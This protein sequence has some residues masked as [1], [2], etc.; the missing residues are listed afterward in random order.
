[1]VRARSFA[2]SI[3]RLRRLFEQTEVFYYRKWSLPFGAEVVG[4]EE[5]AGSFLTFVIYT[6]PFPSY[7]FICTA[8]FY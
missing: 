7:I 2:I 3:K 8:E 4:G 6:R 1:M 5:M